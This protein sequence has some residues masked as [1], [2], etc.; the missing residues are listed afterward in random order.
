[1]KGGKIVMKKIIAFALSI[2]F[3]AEVLPARMSVQDKK[4]DV[5]YC[6]LLKS[7]KIILTAD[8]KQVYSEVKLQKGIKLTTGGIVIYPNGSKIVLK[9]GECIDREGNITDLSNTKKKK[10]KDN[11][12]M[13]L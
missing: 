8:G 7:G 13:E 1:M 4:D 10:G 9:N 2:C 5:S 12:T 6:A 11:N 3:S